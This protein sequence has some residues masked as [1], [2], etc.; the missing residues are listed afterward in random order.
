MSSIRLLTQLEFDTSYKARV[1]AQAKEKAE[2]DANRKIVEDNNKRI[3]DHKRDLFYTELTDRVFL[4]M[5]E[6]EPESAKSYISRIFRNGSSYYW[7]N[8]CLNCGEFSSPCACADAR[9][10][11]NTM[12]IV[13]EELK[14]A[15][16]QRQKDLENATNDTLETIKRITSL[17][18]EIHILMGGVPAGE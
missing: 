9:Y 13:E 14:A 11:V 18:Q 10:T 3:E 17:G 1:E 12:V 5:T 7:F 2:A 16:A 15:A 4:S 6:G 8:T